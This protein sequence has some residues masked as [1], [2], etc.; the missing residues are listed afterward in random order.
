MITALTLKIGLEVFVHFMFAVGGRIYNIFKYTAARLRNK[1][2]FCSQL[3]LK[4]I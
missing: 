2:Y 1:L 3:K 4:L